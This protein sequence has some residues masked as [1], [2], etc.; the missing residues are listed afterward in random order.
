MKAIKLIIVTIIQFYAS[1]FGI[2]REEKKAEPV[3]SYIVFI[4]S[5]ESRD[6]YYLSTSEIQNEKTYLWYVPGN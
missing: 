5:N 3:E 4:S 2:E 1:M 6:Y